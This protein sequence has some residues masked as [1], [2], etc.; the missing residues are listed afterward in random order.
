[1]PT[2]NAI[3]PSWL[4]RIHWV[5]ITSEGHKASV[6]SFRTLSKLPSGASERVLALRLEYLEKKYLK[7]VQS[8]RAMLMAAA[9]HNVTDETLAWKSKTRI[10]RLAGHW[11]FRWQR[12]EY[13]KPYSRLPD[14]AK[15][16]M[17]RYPGAYAALFLRATDEFD[18]F[19]GSFFIRQYLRSLLWQG[20]IWG[21][22][23]VTYAIAAIPAYVL[24]TGEVMI[25]TTLKIGPIHSFIA[26]YMIS[27]VIMNPA[28][29][30]LL[31][32]LHRPILRINHMHPAAA[33]L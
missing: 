15:S 14:I 25:R 8:V 9:V 28:V 1:M 17:S 19:I 16:T 21:S 29:S 12:W 20:L 6:Y 22:K 24:S 33:S 18:A 4:L 27:I 11:F 5:M 26:C 3:R 2:S 30:F 7:P 13:R 10:V 23:L 31:H 32:Q